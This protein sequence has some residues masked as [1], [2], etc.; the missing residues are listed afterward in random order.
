MAVVTLATRAAGLAVTGLTL[1]DWVQR[2][3]GHVP[4]AVFTALV[5]PALLVRSAASGPE[6]AAGPGLAAGL[7]GALAA[8]R[9][10]SVIATIAAGL[11]VFWALRWLGL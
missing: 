7:V 4:V 9:T 11:A 2:W 6:L 8:W 1:P 10:S 3:L 5:V